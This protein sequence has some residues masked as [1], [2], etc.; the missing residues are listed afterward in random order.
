MSVEIVETHFYAFEM[1]AQSYNFSVKV[2][3]LCDNSPFGKDVEAREGITLQPTNMFICI[4]HERDNLTYI[5]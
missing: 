2:S 5:S 3:P 1:T 4:S